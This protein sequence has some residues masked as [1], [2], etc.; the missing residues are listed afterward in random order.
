MAVI[1]RIIGVSL[2]TGGLGAGLGFVFFGKDPGWGGISLLLGCVGAI[3]G[4][5]AGTAREIVTALRQKPSI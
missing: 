2:L 1:A 3:I 4:A 5:L